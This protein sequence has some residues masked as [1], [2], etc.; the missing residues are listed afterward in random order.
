M[1][2]PDDEPKAET[3]DIIEFPLPSGK[4][5]KFAEIDPNEFAAFVD[6]MPLSDEAKQGLVKRF[7]ARWEVA[8]GQKWRGS[9]DTDSPSES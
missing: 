5:P 8:H 4:L 3:G 1:T 2:N 9:T 7:I 6:G